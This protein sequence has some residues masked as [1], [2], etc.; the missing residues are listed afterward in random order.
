MKI[1]VITNVEERTLPRVLV[2]VRL[3]PIVSRR[4]ELFLLKGSHLL[5][6]RFQRGAESPSRTGVGT[7][8]ACALQ[9][10]E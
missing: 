5:E 8:G 3:G 2:P 4:R 7:R 6:A 10:E 9:C 1:V